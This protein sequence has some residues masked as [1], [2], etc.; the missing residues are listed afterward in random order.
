MAY[1]IPQVTEDS[2]IPYRRQEENFHYLFIRQDAAR[3]SQ[4]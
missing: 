2:T 3:D 1:S 4:T